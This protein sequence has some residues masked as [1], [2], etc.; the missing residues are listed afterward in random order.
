[1]ARTRRRREEREREREKDDNYQHLRL[2]LAQ[3]K[4]KKRQRSVARRSC[5]LLISKFLDQFQFGFIF[6]NFFWKNK[7]S[8]VNFELLENVKDLF[9]QGSEAFHLPER[10]PTQS[11]REMEKKVFNW[12]E[13][14]CFWSN[15]KTWKL[16]E[17][18]V[19]SKQRQKFFRLFFFFFFFSFLCTFINRCTVKNWIDRDSEIPHRTT[20]IRFNSL[21]LR[22]VF[23]RKSW[24]RSAEGS[25]G[26][27]FLCPSII[28]SKW[29][30]CR[31]WGGADLPIRCLVRERRVERKKFD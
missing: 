6:S 3:I 19:V 14:R 15:V 27:Y 10:L 1:M 31:R 16:D 25:S 23:S 5:F 21:V 8:F 13:L 2:L 12:T 4:M 11:D 24:Q 20:I 30:M 29:W 9:A 22:T 7:F 18:V 28:E 26:E 17:N